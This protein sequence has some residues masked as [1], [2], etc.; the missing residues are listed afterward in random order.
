MSHAVCAGGHLGEARPLL[1][2][3]AARGF[4]LLPCIALARRVL[5]EDHPFTS[6]RADGEE[7]R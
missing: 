6:A 5:A 2:G 7:R 3:R 4:A 1:V